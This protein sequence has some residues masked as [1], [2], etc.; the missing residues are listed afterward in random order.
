MQKFIA[1]SPNAEIRSMNDIL[2]TS[3]R[4]ESIKPIMDR[5]GFDFEKDTREW[6]PQQM[7]LDLHRYIKEEGD[8]SLAL[9]SLG[10]RILDSV[11]FPP[12]PDFESA[13]RGFVAS[14]RQVHRNLAPQDELRFEIIGPHHYQI[15]NSTPYPDELVYGYIY[16]VV[17][18]F[19]PAKSHPSLAYHDLKALNTDGEMAFDIKW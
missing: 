5:Y 15:I 8:D 3:T 18:R 2:F 1:S 4:Y 16:S 14:Y 6:L 17:H 19:R 9:V 12:M 10:T 7:I 11:P 13:L